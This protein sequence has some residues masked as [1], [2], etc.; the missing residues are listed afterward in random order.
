[1]T[2]TTGAVVIKVGGSLLDWSELP[3][4]LAAFLD[5]CRAEDPTEAGRFLLMA[6]GGPAADLIRNSDQIHGLG[7]T[8]AHWLAIRAMDLTAA[9]LAALLPGAMVVSRPEVL[10]S[11]WNLDRIPVL[12]PSR[13]LE[14]IDAC[15]PEPLP[16]GWHVTSDSIAAQIA[17]HLRARRLI[18]LKSR[19]APEG[20]SREDAARLG[21]VDAWFPAVARELEVVDLVCLRDDWSKIQRLNDRS[22]SH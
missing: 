15:G 10:R 8:R 6:G 22:R 16:E 4:R 11:V 12:A 13:M 20:T 2:K 14:E 1:M 21:L 17:V 5:R 7:D 3:G 18:L 9:L 19:G